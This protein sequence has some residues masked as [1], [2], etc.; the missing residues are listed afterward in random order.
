MFSKQVDNIRN[1]I[2]HQ[3]QHSDFGCTLKL[4]KVAGIELDIS[5]HFWKKDI[6]DNFNAWLTYHDF[7]NKRDQ[8]FKGDIVNISENQPALHTA[9]RN[10]SYKHLYG[11]NA[12]IADKIKFLHHRMRELVNNIHHPLN[13]EDEITDIVHIGMGGSV[14]GT[15]LCYHALKHYRVTNIRC[16]FISIMDTEVIS[17]L[18]ATLNPKKTLFVLAS[19][20]FTTE[21]MLY[22]AS[23]AK[24]WINNNHLR[25]A[26]HFIAVTAQIE[27]AVAWG[28]LQQNVLPLWDWVGGRFSVWSA[29]SISLAI[30]IGMDNFMSLLNGAEI[31]DQH[32]YNASFHENFPIQLACLSAWYTDFWDRQNHAIPTLCN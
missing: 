5:Q 29:V 17:T 15:E 6:A 10:L 2:R 28:I 13:E 22:Q 26:K 3:Q 27:K 14:L 30:S 16:H 4:P 19:K 25:T 18:L 12:G 23:I 1:D 8:L 11:T 7:A 32:F 20:S 21:E 24:R 9:L 31:M